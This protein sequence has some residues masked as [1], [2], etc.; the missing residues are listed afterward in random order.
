VRGAFDRAVRAVELTVAARGKTGAHLR[1]KTVAV[2]GE[3]NIDEVKDMLRLAKDLQV[4][5]IE[6]IPL[7]DFRA[8]TGDCETPGASFLNKVDETLRSVSRLDPGVR[9]ENSPVHLKLFRRS[10]SRSPLPLKCHAGYNSLAVDCYGNVYPCVPWYNWSRP[11]GIVDGR[12]LPELWY[13]R[14]YQAV[15]KETAACRGCYLNC[16]AELNILFNPL[17]SLR[18]KRAAP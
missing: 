8:K 14:Q 17:I 7:Q 4:D 12:G 16:Q 15:R 3:R 1:I 2:L 13:S 9:I 5:C 18:L 11:A 10:F 6:F